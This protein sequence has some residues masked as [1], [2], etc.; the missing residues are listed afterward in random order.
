MPCW[1]NILYFYFSPQ[2]QVKGRNK[3]EHRLL[4]VTK[5]AV[6][7]LDEKSKEILKEWPLAQVKRWAATQNIFTIDFGEYQDGFYSVQT[8]E[9]DKISEIIAGYIDIICKD[10]EIP[11][12]YD[13]EGTEQ[14]IIE[15]DGG[16][17]RKGAKIIIPQKVEVNS[18]EQ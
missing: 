15:D 6:L 1:Y 4:G 11:R 18:Y 16:S 3:L 12:G 5:S 8:P 7:R 13:G 17:G 2:E 14:D 10:K 9:G